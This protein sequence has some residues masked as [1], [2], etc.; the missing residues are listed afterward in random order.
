MIRIFRRLD[1]CANWFKLL[2]KTRGRI[3]WLFPAGLLALYLI[4]MIPY[5]DV[6][7][8]F[9]LRSP[10]AS[11]L[12]QARRLGLDFDRVVS[13]PAAAVGKPVVWCVSSNNGEHGFVNGNPS[14]PVV[15][16][17][18]SAQLQTNDGSHG[19]CLKELAVVEGFDRGAVLLRPVERL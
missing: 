5:L 3:L 13:E 17:H 8:S 9:R 15:W 12:A 4:S 10:N 6:L 16:A 1:P 19:H 7:S 18:P 2:A 14:L 11:M